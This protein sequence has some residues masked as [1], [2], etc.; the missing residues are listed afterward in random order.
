M[1]GTR[2]QEYLVPPAER[3]TRPPG[4]GPALAAWSSAPGA[5]E[6]MK[7]GRGLAAAPLLGGGGG[8][9]RG[10]ARGDHS[11][12]SPSSSAFFLP[13]ALAAFL[14]RCATGASKNSSACFHNGREYSGGS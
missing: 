2:A 3:V 4:G 8:S 5:G 12:S 10:P 11:S 7:K 1:W 14:E 6:T 9:Q 13:P